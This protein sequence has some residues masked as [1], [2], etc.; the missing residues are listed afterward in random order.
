MPD[1]APAHPPSAP[2]RGRRPVVA[3]SRAERQRRERLVEL[4]RGPRYLVAA[5]AAHAALFAWLLTLE[6][7]APPPPREQLLRASAQDE[8]PPGLAEEPAPPAPEAPSDEPL[9][10]P[11][12]SEAPA[13][14]PEALV[15]ELDT[16]PASDVLG[17]GGGA[18]G[19]GGGGRRGSGLATQPLELPGVGPGG[20]GFRLFVEDLRARGLDVVFVVD[21]TASMERF[22]AAAR[23]TIDDIIADLSAVVP[24]LRLGLVAYRDRSD[25]WLTQKAALTDNRYAIHNFLLDLTAEGGGDFEEAVEEGLRVA[26]ED[27]EWRPGA[28]RI[29]VL[30]GDAPPHAEDQSRALALVRAFARDRESALSALFTGGQGMQSLVE[31]DRLAREAFAALARSGGGV[32]SELGESAAELQQQILDASFGTEFK[33]EL[34]ALL[35]SRRADLR[36]RIVRAKVQQG[37]RAWLLQRLR[38]VPV[39]PAVV[40]GCVQLFDAAVAWQALALLL[41]E[42]RDPVS[43]SAMLYLLRKRAAP[44]VSLDLA[45]PL[46]QQADRVARL[47]REVE[48]LGPPPPGLQLPGAPPAGGVVAPPPAR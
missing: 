25:P 48:R 39:H 28:R 1:D 4:R 32:L 5:L 44:F 9:P 21:A 33:D 30:V 45:R 42:A 40:D 31:R 3:L 6:T 43:R 22:I 15:A 37:D 19:G 27:L 13:D 10:D 23:A 46:A 11:F 47:R 20:S 35:A 16:G 2:L 12:E 18:G 41:D 38:D 17:L 8:P 26:I 36:A 7:D 29:L 24:D 34:R 14:G